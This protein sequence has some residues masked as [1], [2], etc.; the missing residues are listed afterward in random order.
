MSCTPAP[1]FTS[2]SRLFSQCLLTLA[3]FLPMFLNENHAF[4]SSPRKVLKTLL[5]AS[6][7]SSQPNYWV[8]ASFFWRSRCPLCCTLVDT[9]TSNLAT[10]LASILA[11]HPAL[12]VS[13]RSSTGI[14]ETGVRLSL[15][16]SV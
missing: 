14:D 15:A 7:S 10:V 11:P 12:L 16:D 6:F 5:V 9:V 4:I 8:A 13:R 3:L 2:E 1:F